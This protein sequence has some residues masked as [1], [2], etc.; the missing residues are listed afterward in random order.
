MKLTNDR[1][2]ILKKLVQ[3]WLPAFGTFYVSLAALWG[4]PYPNQVAGTVL[5]LAT[6]IGVILGISAKAYL[7]D[8]GNFDGNLYITSNEDEDPEIHIA[9]NDKINNVSDVSDNTTVTLRAKKLA[10]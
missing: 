1:Y 9:F 2:D 8:D 10:P 5:A 4:L 6:F 7:D 3:L